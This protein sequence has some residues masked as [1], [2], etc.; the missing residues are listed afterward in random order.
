MDPDGVGFAVAGEAVS[1]SLAA[2]PRVSLDRRALRNIA[3]FSAGRDSAAV[4]LP[5]KRP[6]GPG[7]G[8][9]RLESFALPPRAQRPSRSGAEPV[10]GRA[11]NELGDIP[12]RERWRDWADSRAGWA[13]VIQQTRP[14]SAQTGSPRCARALAKRTGRWRRLQRPAGHSGGPPELKA[15]GRRDRTVH[16]QGWKP[17][18]PTP[19]HSASKDRR[20]SA[21]YDAQL[22]LKRSKWVCSAFG[23]AGFHYRRVAAM[24]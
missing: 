18:L 6:T 12:E 14:W 15:G 4:G 16:G 3:L 22:H 1:V 9:R 7:A 11:P 13:R 19:A 24:H 8:R 5:V 17:W 23:D 21:E 10:V 2:V 20:G